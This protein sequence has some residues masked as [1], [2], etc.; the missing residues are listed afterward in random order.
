M[1]GS[2]EDKMSDEELMGHM[3]YVLKDITG[4]S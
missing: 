1:E 2:E 3:K 4:C